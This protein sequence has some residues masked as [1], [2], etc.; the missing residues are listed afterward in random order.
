MWIPILSLT[1]RLPHLIVLPF[2]LIIWS[3]NAADA[4]DIAIGDKQGPT[5][6][7]GIGISSLVK[8]KLLPS[9]DIDLDPVVTGGNEESLEALRD[10]RV[11]LALVTVDDAQPLAGDEIRALA[12]LGEAD[13]RAKTLL[14]RRDI[15]DASVQRILGTIFNGVDFLAAIEPDLRDLHPDAAIMGLALPLHD[16]AKRFYAQWWSSPDSAVQS[17]ETANAATPAPLPGADA[18][19]A[20]TTS[21]WNEGP[22]DAH[23]FVVYFAFDD[24]ALDD[25][26]W[27]ILRQAAAF[28]RTLSSPAIIV[29]AYTDSVGEAEYNYLLAE[30]R[31]ASVMQGLDAMDIDY[32]RI[33]LAL[34]GE[35]SPWAVTLDDVNEANNRRVELFIEEPVP[36]VQTLPLAEDLSEAPDNVE[37]KESNIIDGFSQ[38]A[39]QP[40]GGPK[41]LIS[42]LPAR[43]VM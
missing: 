9:A 38:G 20:V 6:G 28:A 34:F 23:N 26:A 12:T 10:G 33:D 43:S 24:S 25:E 21:E 13:Q 41:Q 19:Q 32:G 11:A 40:A 15:D 18:N 35:R 7:L 5:Y 4:F 27:A 31:A 36:E 29:A 8:L 39:R 17:S 1:G 22:S 3:V 14:V 16:G 42:P 2:F 37:P 30:R